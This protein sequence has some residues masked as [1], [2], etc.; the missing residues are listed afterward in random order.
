MTNFSIQNL[1]ALVTVFVIFS[2]CL[3][4]YI[5]RIEKQMATLSADIK[6]IKELLKQCQPTSE[7][8]SQ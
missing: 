2:S 5:I 1:F 7:K 8:S 6:W 4:G 3:I